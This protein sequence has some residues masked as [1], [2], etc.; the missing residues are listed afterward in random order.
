[1][2]SI[3]LAL[4]GVL[5]CRAGAERPP[6]EGTLQ[7]SLRD[8]AGE[9]RFSA[10]AEARWCAADTVLEI[11]AVRN[12]SAVGI[13]LFPRDSLRLEGYPIFQAGVFAPWRPQATAGLRL[14]RAN[15][16]RGYVSAWGRVE[17]TQLSGDRVSGTLDLHVK[18][19]GT[20]DSLQLTGGF[21]GVPV[22][23]AAR[24][25]GRANKPATG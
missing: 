12:D 25:C 3:P 11:I 2:R 17:I 23:P 7:A 15:D 10:P 18:A 21:T 19:V 24:P 20:A 6:A 1:M 16:L 4:C 9:A 13:A 5:A 22:R 8:S 14:F